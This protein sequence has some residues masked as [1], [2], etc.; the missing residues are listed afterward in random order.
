MAEPSRNSDPWKTF[1]NDVTSVSLPND[2]RVFLVGSIFGGTGAAGVPTFGSRKMLKHNELASFE[3]GSRIYLGGCLVLPY[4][5]VDM[6]AESLAENEG[7]LFV[8]HNDFPIATKAALQ[9]YDEKEDL[10]FDEL[11]FVGDSEAEPV[12][13]FAPGA[14]KQVNRA[15]YIELVSAL[16]ALDFFR[17]PARAANDADKRYFI[18]ARDGSNVDWQSLPVTRDEERLGPE[19]DAFRLLMSSMSIFSYAL[20]TYGKEVLAQPEKERPSWF[21]DDEH[22]GRRAGKQEEHDMSLAENSTAVDLFANFGRDFLQWLTQVADGNRRVHLVDASKIW[23]E[24][25]DLNDRHRLPNAIASLITAPSKQMDFNRFVEQMNEI[26]L[27]NRGMR[28]SDKYLNL[29]Y[30]GAVSYCESNYGMS[31]PATGA[32]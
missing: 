22:F 6:T 31:V 1:W 5:T 17:A 29:F 20:A 21:R 19:R 15:H 10:A 32:K 28:A 24:R 2:V 26:H 30:E 27:S 9:F 25:G 12:G 7:N 8:T 4:F 23:N 13:T 3:K 14:K 11:Y 18:A 16:T